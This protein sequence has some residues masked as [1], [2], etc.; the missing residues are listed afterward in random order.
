MQ[1]KHS[2]FFL[3][4]RNINFKSFV[5]RVKRMSDYLIKPSSVQ[6]RQFQ[7]LASLTIMPAQRMNPVE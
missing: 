6:S 4:K 1:C 2:D 3:I 7:T 5:V